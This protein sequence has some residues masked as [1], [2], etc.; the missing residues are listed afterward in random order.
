MSK[1]RS[2]EG[3]IDVHVHMN[4]FWRMKDGAKQTMREHSSNYDRSVELARQPERFI[5][6]LDTQ[7]VS[8]AAI[9]NYVSP[10]VGYTHSTNEWAAAFRNAA[11]DRILAFGG[12][13]PRLADNPV[14]EINRALNEFA[15][16]GIKIHPPHQGINVNDYRSDPDTRE[17][18][19][20]ATLYKRCADQEIPIMVHTGTSIFSGAR[21]RYAD[22]M[23]IDDVAVDYPNLTIIMAHGGRPMYTEEAWFLLRRHDNLYL[24]ISSFPPSNLL[25]YFPEIEQIDE[26]VLF[27]SDWPGPMVPDIHQNIETIQNLPL[28]DRTTE[29]ILYQNAKELFGL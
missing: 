17:L 6:Y 4:P 1:T 21:S 24:D 11:P 23:P 29:R 18:D 14:A 25:E 13:D 7:N 20:L 5:D 8:V 9:I 3:V 12:F 19:D 10:I 26:Q 16:D 28:S 22:P 27:G 2:E 15:L